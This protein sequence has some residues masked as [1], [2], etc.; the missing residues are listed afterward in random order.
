MYVLLCICILSI[1]CAMYESNSLLCLF[2]CTL[3]TL[4]EYLQVY[5]PMHTPYFS[6][7]PIAFSLLYGTAVYE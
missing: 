7:Y 3:G 2:I 5:L 6:C 1:Y 4:Y